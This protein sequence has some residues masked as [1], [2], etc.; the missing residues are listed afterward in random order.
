MAC[1]YKHPHGSINV[2]ELDAILNHNNKTFLFVDFN[3]KHPSWNPGRGNANG[4]ILSNWAVSSAND[5]IAPDTPTHFNHN[6]P[7]TV[8]D[9][10]FAA[11]FSHSVFTINELSSDHNPVIF[12]FV[13]NCYLPPLLQTL[14]STNWIKFQE[15]LFYNMPGNPTIDNLDQAVQ[16]FS[17]IVSDAI[18]TSTSTRVIKTTHLRLP[19][20]IR[21]LIK[22]KN[23]F[24]KLWNN[25]RYPPYKREVNA[26]TRQI[27]IEINEHKNRT[28]KN[29]LSTLNTEDNSLYNL[30]KIITK[31]HT[32]IP[33]LPGPSGI[34]Y[35]YFEKAEACKDTLEVTF[36]ENAEPY[37]DDKIEEVESLVNH[38][39][40]NFNMHIP[41]LT[42]PLEV[43]VIIK[44]IT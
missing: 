27:R 4:N 6:A 25:T 32:V 31:T 43:R 14:K 10:G 24:R 18:N 39:F 41:P 16:N 7:S 20:N 19:I 35:S 12:D 21:E 5:I 36:Q 1:I 2:T 28:Y 15:I 26:L 33:P 40:D 30:H 17:N 22:T 9:I 44:K 29:L 42:S 11:N 23:R 38:Y 13:I 3:A 37:S 8:I 34:A